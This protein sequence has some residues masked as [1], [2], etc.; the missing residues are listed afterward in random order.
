MPEGNE[1]GQDVHR[2][3]QERIR[4]LGSTV[5]G[6]KNTGIEPARANGYGY[7]S[8]AKNPGKTETGSFKGPAGSSTTRR[9]DSESAQPQFARTP[10][11]IWEVFPRSDM[12]DN[13]LGAESMAE[14]GDTVK[15]T[16]FGSER[17]A[18]PWMGNMV[19]NL[20]DDSGEG[21]ARDGEVLSTLGIVDGKNPEEVLAE[22]R[23]IRVRVRING[24]I[25]GSG[26]RSV[27]MFEQRGPRDGIG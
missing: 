20:G 10:G 24:K 15:A 3:R 23:T 18:L 16:T 12:R 19:G 4:M 7:A 1:G 5:K 17:R 8:T 11:S 26:K 6:G 13:D 14:S 21:Y 22:M 2:W 27:L 9:R 25:A